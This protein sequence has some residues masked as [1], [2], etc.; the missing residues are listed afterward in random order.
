MGCWM[1]DIRDSEVV[2]WL[3]LAVLF[4]LTWKI[5]LFVCPSCLIIIIVVFK[6]FIITTGKCRHRRRDCC[7]FLSIAEVHC[8]QIELIVWW[9]AHWLAG[10][11]ITWSWFFVKRYINNRSEV[12]ALHVGT[13]WW[14]AD[15]HSTVH[16]GTV[17]IGT[18]IACWQEAMCYNHSSA[19]ARGCSGW[20]P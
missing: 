7:F 12:K 3:V 17:H 8:C 20:C 4:V 6:L 2:T 13:M 5:C 14:E 18:V 9:L 10:C 19:S 11:V 16:A 15:A 1:N